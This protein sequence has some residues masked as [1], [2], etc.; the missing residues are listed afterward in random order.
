LV[1]QHH[2][3]RAGT[4][5]AGIRGNALCHGS[6]LSSVGASANPGP[7]HGRFEARIRELVAGQLRLEMI[8]APL[9]AVRRVLREPLAKLHKMV[10]DQ[11]RSD[12]LCRRL[13]AVG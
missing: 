6:I 9:P 7:V 5:L 3:H 1:V 13:M 12:K 11:V 10:L 2:P 8:V 4:H